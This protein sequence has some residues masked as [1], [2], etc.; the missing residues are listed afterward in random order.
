M[1]QLNVVRP[2]V[3]ARAV[4]QAIGATQYALAYAKRRR[5]FGPLL[6]EHEAIAFDL[7]ELAMEIE[8]ARLLTYRAAWLVDQGGTDRAVA[9]YLSMAKAKASE[10]AV[11]VPVCRCT[12]CKPA[13][14]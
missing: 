3:A 13:E 10:L 7:A 2:L 9:H 12:S 11:S 4:G 8:A 14:L 5:S 6:I 1:R